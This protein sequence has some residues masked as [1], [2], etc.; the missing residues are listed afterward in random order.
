MKRIFLSIVFLFVTIAESTPS[1]LRPGQPWLDTAGEQIN[2]HGFCI[3]RHHD[4]YYWFGSQKIPGKT[5]D[6]PNEAGVSCYTSKDLLSWTNAG[7]VLDARS[8][9]GPA[10]LKDAFI[11]DRPK[12]IYHAQTKR[13]ILY[14]KLYPPKEQGGKSGKDFAY[15]GV[16]T[17]ATPTGPYEYQ[18]KFLG[19][20]ST[21]G[22]G[23]FAIYQE[24]DGAVYH[25]AVRKPDG[26]RSDKP[27]V[28]GKMTEDGLRPEG[29]YVMM[30]GVQNATEAPVLFKRKGKYYLLGSASTG[31]APNPARFYV[32]DQLTGPFTALGNPCRGVNP[33]NKLGAEKTF[34]GQSTFVFPLAGQ[35]DR[36]IAMFDINLPQDPVH[37]GYIWLPLQF[38]QNNHAT[39]PWQSEWF[40]Q[41]SLR[42]PTCFGNHMVLQREQSVPV[43]GWSEPNAEVSVSFDNQVQS[44]MSDNKGYW[45]VKLKA[46][47]A[48]ESPSVLKITS[49]GQS[50][51]VTD[52]L[53]GDVWLCSGQSNMHFTMARVENSS[54]EIAAAQHPTIRFFTVHDQF[55]KVPLTELSGQWK[56]INPSTAGAC[57][58]VSYYFGRDLQK[59]TGLP[60]GLLVSSVGGTRIESWMRMETLENSNEAATLLTKWKDVSAAELASIVT[61]YRAYQYQ[62]DQVH[63]KAVAQAK[64]EGKPLP[65][66]PT[67]PK[68]RGHD[69]P[70]ALH[71]GMIAP[72]QPFSVRGAIWYQGESNAGQAAAYE[73]LLPALISDWRTVWGKDMPFLFVQ[74][75]PHHSI[76]PSIREAQYHVWRNTPH[77]AMVVTTD[78]GDAN[79]IHPTRKQPVGARLALAARAL[80]YGEPVI[81]SGPV[82]DRIKID[83]QRAMVFFTHCGSG[84]RVQGEQLKGFTLA[85]ADGIY[86]PADAIVDG[87]TV[88]VSS[89]KVTSPKHVR[90]CWAKVPEG[91][92]CNSVGLPAVPFRSDDFIYTSKSK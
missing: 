91:N 75:A 38:D 66:L 13:F 89:E 33:H 5:E 25:I 21:T 65:A 37:S 84:L 62:R 69:C 11:L 79:D 73:K 58:A 44:T 64:T 6:E 81:S 76:H 59:Q 83:A 67:A 50:I 30:Q 3:L 42:L 41:H 68:I 19:G 78:V 10:E 36:W 34:G 24:D 2:A 80:S 29:E 92:L 85:G 26:T 8:P 17:A 54:Q 72:L 14:F 32:S 57:S 71:N 56:P 35:E 39:I 77:T 18:G 86:H 31:W 60:I 16:A 28:C 70:G 4:T 45:I 51:D 46:L 15:I 52:V 9:E 1:P 7:L 74:L 88:I 63:P 20:E 12:V 48:S 22:S 40:P 90:Y 87:E 27:L 23:D 47:S 61:K 43:W 55:S 49:R 53:V 82:F